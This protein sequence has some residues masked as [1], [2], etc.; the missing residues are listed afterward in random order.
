MVL[1]VYLHNLVAES[2][3]NGMLSPHP[4]LNVD[5]AVRVIV[6]NFPLLCLQFS[7]LSVILKV[8]SKMLKERYF[9]LELFR[10]FFERVG[11]HNVLLL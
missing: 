6:Y 10:V 2:E 4:F 7:L 5:L 8:G 9:L 11:S 1:K 3:H